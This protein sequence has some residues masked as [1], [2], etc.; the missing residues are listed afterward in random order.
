VKGVAAPAGPPPGFCCLLA[1]RPVCP[2]LPGPLPPGA[3]APLPAGGG[4]CP[5]AFLA[6]EG[7]GAAAGAGVAPCLPP[8]LLFPAFPGDAAADCGFGPGPDPAGG[9]GFGVGAAPALAPEFVAAGIFV[10]VA[11]DAGA[12]DLAGDFFSASFSSPLFFPAGGGG[13]L[14]LGSSSS[15]LVRSI[16]APPFFFG[17]SAIALIF[18]SSSSV[19]FHVPL[20]MKMISVWLGPT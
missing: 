5:P 9:V 16:T 7:T 4:P 11:E 1:R 15:S 8:L 10:P 19:V 13:A 3:G 18:V 12:A 17:V 6:C 20:G 14:S 2:G